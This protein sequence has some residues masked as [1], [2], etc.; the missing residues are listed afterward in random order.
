VPSMSILGKAM[1]AALLLVL[2][3]RES[4]RRPAAP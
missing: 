2:G 3:V 1:L 4:R